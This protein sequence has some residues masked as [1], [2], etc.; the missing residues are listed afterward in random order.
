MRIS[1]TPPR[2]SSRFYIT[3]L[4][5]VFFGSFLV[6]YFFVFPRLSEILFKTNP[7]QA[8]SFRQKFFYLAIGFMPL[9]FLLNVYV[10]KKEIS[11]DK[12]EARI[13]RNL[14][15]MPNNLVEQNKLK[16]LQKQRQRMMNIVEPFLVLCLGII[17]GFFAIS[18]MRPLFEIMSEAK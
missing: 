2:A 8:E 7:R 10:W 9:L 18:I 14:E 13:L 4:S 17:V 3:F 11:L 1:T 5:L 15:L 6:I 16:T 12:E